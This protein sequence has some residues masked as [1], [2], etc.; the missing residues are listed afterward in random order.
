[1][2]GSWNYYAKRGMAKSLKEAVDVEN[3]DILPQGFWTRI[4]EREHCCVA[5]MHGNGE[6]LMEMEAGWHFTTST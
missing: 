6:E 1:M 3:A 5:D 2:R 4:V